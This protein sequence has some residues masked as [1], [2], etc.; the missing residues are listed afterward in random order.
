MAGAEGFLLLLADFFASDVLDGA[1]FFAPAGLAAE[2]LF[3]LL[4]DGRVAAF[5]PTDERFAAGAW[6]FFAPDDFLLEGSF[7]A[8]LRQ[9]L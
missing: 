9:A 6:D 4:G 5:L 3:F 2:T 7:L 8:I 1:F